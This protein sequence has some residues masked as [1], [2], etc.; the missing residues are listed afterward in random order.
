MH[1]SSGDGPN[2]SP[3]SKDKL[4]YLFE[5]QKSLITQDYNSKEI[6][7]SQKISDVTTYRWQ[8]RFV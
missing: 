6:Q 4:E 2:R 3:E 7:S 5:M 8:R 1:D